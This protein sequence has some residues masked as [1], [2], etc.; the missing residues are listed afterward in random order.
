MEN[1]VS[2]IEETISKSFELSVMMGQQS[3]YSTLDKF[4]ENPDINTTSGPEDIWEGGGLYTYDANGT[5]PIVSIASSSSSDTQDI[6]VTGSDI[7]GDEVTQTITLTGTTRKALTTPLW[8]VYRMSNEGTVNVAGNVFC[9][10]GTGTVPSIGDAEVRALIN[11]G[12]NQTLMAQYTMPKGK[13][14]FLY[15]G[16]IGMSR[17]KDSG[18]AQCS[19]Y[20][21]RYGKVFRV[22]KR[23]AI[24]NSG[25]SVYQDA[26]SFPD[27]IPAL[28]DIKLTVESVD[29]NDI[30]VFGTFDIMLIDENKFTT[31]YLQAI[32]QPGF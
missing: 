9:Y 21:R 23:I 25:S 19:Y 7:E 3:G 6:Q 32:G 24:T 8:R 4:G 15:R 1:P 18:S 22:K 20:S 13:V 12:N 29:E 31:A 5:A 28:T 2:Y 14:G 16:E 27:I 10:T 30:G 26:R 11:N 17:K